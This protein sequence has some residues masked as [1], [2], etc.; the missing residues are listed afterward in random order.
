MK[1]TLPRMWSGRAVG[2][3]TV[4]LAMAGCGTSARDQVKSKVEQFATA[5]AHR[6]YKTLCS[7]VLAPSLVAH[8]K[9]AGLGCEEA[10]GIALA[11]VQN[12]AL[13]IGKITVRGSKASVIALTL[14][15]G[16]TASVS[17]I[18]LIKTSRGWRIASLG[19]NLENAA[20]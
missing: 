19:A 10:M 9:G 13:S 1:A 14:A 20:R 5:A 12:P 16:Q 11:Q 15:T 2:I 7:Q 6:D 3:M 18:D 4:A 8:L 17:A